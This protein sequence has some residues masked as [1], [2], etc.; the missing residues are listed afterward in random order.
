M[1]K[2][3]IPAT[4][5]LE[6]DLAKLIDTEISTLKQLEDELGYLKDDDK[7]KW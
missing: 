4:V 2:K 3:F 6:Y 1:K 7:S 5:T